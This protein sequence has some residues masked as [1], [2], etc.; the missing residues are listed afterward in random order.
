MAPEQGRCLRVSQGSIEPCERCRPISAWAVTCAQGPPLSP[1]AGPPIARS[2]GED[3]E[4]AVTSEAIVDSM[5]KSIEGS[6]KTD[7]P[8]KHW[9]LTSCLPADAAETI[10]NL[11]FPAPDLGGIS[12]KREVHNATRKYSDAE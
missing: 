3:R 1:A 4:M 2:Q 6:K 12:G 10:L 5:L 8:Y 11:P 7:Q 9:F